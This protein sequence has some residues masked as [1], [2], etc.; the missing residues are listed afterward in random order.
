MKAKD[1]DGRE[2]HDYYDRYIRKLNENTELINGFIEGGKNT[3]SFF[4]ALANDKYDFRYA[5]GKWSIR[6]VLQHLIDTERIFS[7]RCFRIARRDITPLAGFDQSIYVDPSSA[8]D[9]SVAQL[10]E[11]Y[12]V[13]RTATISLLKSLSDQ[14]LSFI[15]NSNGGAMSARAAAFIIIGHDIWHIDMIQ[16]RYL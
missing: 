6:E 13:G 10:Q 3:L 12:R 15:G 7:H 16:E 1:L 14:D 11:E 8:K 5:P 2:Y 4:T 9:K